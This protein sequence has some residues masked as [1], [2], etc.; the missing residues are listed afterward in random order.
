M[1]WRR[2]PRGGKDP[3]PPVPEPTLAPVR[4]YTTDGTIE[5]WVD[6]ARQRLS[7]LLNVEDLLSVSRVEASPTDDDWFVV[8]RDQMLIVVPPP[9]EVDR[10]IRLHRLKRPMHAEVGPYAIRGFV[11][12]IA[13]ITL[14]AMLARSAQYFLPLTDVSVTDPAQSLIE[15]HHTVLVNVR[16]SRERL[17]LEVLE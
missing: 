5:G 2:S 7:D 1:F 16:I 17:K 4:I 13:G 14:D 8:E 6:I 15:Q 11:H 9:R 12:L 3:T 10:Q